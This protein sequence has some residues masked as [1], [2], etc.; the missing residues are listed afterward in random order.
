MGLT[1]LHQNRQDL[2]WSALPQTIP[3]ISLLS[4]TS[5]TNLLTSPFEDVLPLYSRSLILE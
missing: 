4:L 5:Y 2:K 3:I 1:L